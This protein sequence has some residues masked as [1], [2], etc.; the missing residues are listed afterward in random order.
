MRKI[1]LTFAILVFSLVLF[2][3]FTENFDGW[4]DG[5]YAGVV[6]YEHTGVGHWENNNAMVHS[7]YARSGNAV[8]FNDDSSST[9]EYLLFKGLDGNGKDGGI[10][11]ISFWYRHWDGNVPS[12]PI[13]F[14]VEYQVG[15]TT[16]D[17]TAIGSSVNVTSTTYTEYSETANISGDDIFFRVRNIQDKERLL[18]DD[19][20]VT[21]YSGGAVTTPVIS[22]ISNTPTTPSPSEDVVVSATITDD[23]TINSAVINWGLTTGSLTNNVTMSIDSGDVYVGTI[24][25]QADGATVYY[26]ITAT[27]NDSNAETS[28]ERS[29]DVVLPIVATP[30]FTPGAGIYSETQSVEILCSTV[31][32]SIYYTTDG[33][34]PTDAST[35]Y[36]V[37]LSIDATTTVKAKA[38][39]TG[40]GPSAVA[41]AL[42]DFA[43]A[44]P[45]NIYISEYIE[46]S[47]NNKAIEIYNAGD[48]DVNL[49]FVEFWRI[50]NGG[51]WAV[52]GSGNAVTLSGT[53]APGDVYVVCNSSASAEIQALSDLVG[54]SVCYFN[55]DDAMGLVYNGTLVDVVGDE[56]ADPGS[57]W[58]VAGETDAT[59]NHTLLRKTTGAATTDW[60]ASSGTNATDSQW[61]VMANDDIS[62]LGQ[63]TP[64]PAANPAPVI[65]NIAHT[66]ETPE[67]TDIVTVTADI[68]DD[69]GLTSA[70][71]NWGL[72]SDAMTNNVAMTLSRDAYEGNIPAQVG[73]TTV[74]YEIVAID[75]NAEPATTTSATYDYTVV[76]IVNVADIATLRAG[77]TDG[78]IYCLTGEAVLTYQQSYRGQKFVQDATA[79]ILIDDNSGNITTTYNIYDGITGLCGTL[80]E[81][82]GM[83]QF[84]PVADPGAASNT[85]LSI[86]PVVVTLAD[87]TANFETYE[88]Q[89]VTV[90]DLTFGET[91]NFAN[92]TV[93]TLSDGTDSY[94]FRTSFYDVDYIGTA[95]PSGTVSISGIMNSR[96]DG[97]YIS[98]RDAADIVTA[99]VP[100]VA[101]PTFNPAAG[102][103]ATAQSVEILCATAGASIYYTTDGT[104]PDET[105]T[106]YTVAIDVTETTTIRAKAYLVD[107]TASD[108]AEAVYTIEAIVAPNIYISEYIEGS[109]S[110][111]AF[112]IYNADTVP[113]DLSMVQV[114][115]ISNGG[116][117]SEGA[118]NGTTLVGTLNPGEVW[119][120]ANSSA[121]PEIQA[122][123]DSVGSSI[124]WFN[125]D[126]AMGLAYNGVLIDVVGQEGIDPGTGWDVAGVTAATANHTLLRKSSVTTGTTDWTTSAGTDA[127]DSQWIVLGEDDY[128]NLGDTTANYNEAPAITNILVNPVAPEVGMNVTI[129]ADVTDD[130]AVSTVELK[131][132]TETGV[133]GTVVTMNTRATYTTTLTT[134]T[135]GTYYFVVEA[136]DDGSVVTTSDEQTF[137]VTEP[138]PTEGIIVSETALAFAAEVGATSDPQEYT[139]Q[140]IDLGDVINIEVAGPFEVS[141]NALSWDTDIYDLDPDFDGTIWVRYT[142]TAAGDEFGTITHMSD[143]FDDVVINLT[144]TGSLPLVDIFNEDFESTTLG[145][146]TPV[147]VI[148]DQA[149]EARSYSGNYYAYMSGFS[150]SAQDNEDWLISPAVNMDAYENEQLNFDTAYNYTGPALEVYV[151]TDYVD[152]PTTATWAPLNPVL[153]TGGFS[154]ANSG[155][156]D[157]SGYNGSLRV[158]FKYQS[159]PTNGSAAWEIDNIVMQGTVIQGVNTAPVVTNVMTSPAVPTSTDIVTVTADIADADGISS[160][161]LYWGLASDA[162][163]NEVPMTLNRD[164]YTADIPAQTGGTVVYLKVMATD[165]HVEPMTGESG[166][167]NY[168][169]IQD[170]ADIAALRAGATDGTYYQLAGEVILTFQQ[171][172]RGQKYVQ[173]ASGAI[174]IDD[175]AGAITTAYN[176]YDGITGLWG[177]LS[178]YGEMLQFVPAGDPGAATTTGNTITPAVVTLTDLTNNFEMYEAQVVTVNDVNFEDVGNFANGTV[179]SVSDGAVNYSF[180]STFYDVDYIG[181][182]IPSQP[183]NITG[184]MNSRSTGEYLTARFLTDLDVNETVVAT[185][186]FTPA[187]G[188]YTETQNVEILCDTADAMIY[189]TTDGTDPDESSSL[190]SV[191]I[192]VSETTTIK[193]KAYK[194]GFTP[195]SISE[196][197]YTIVE[198]TEVNIYISEYL[199]GSSNN[200]AIEIYNAGADPVNLDLVEFWRIS[201]G[202]D[203]AVEGSGNAV[204]LSGTLAP[205]DVYVVCNS[206]A[207]PE[208]QAVS[209][210]VGTSICYFNGDDAMGLAYNGVL[211]DVVGD[212]G[213]DPGS[214]WDVAGETAATA[215]HTLLRKETV[216]EATTDWA[217]SA[218]DATDSQWTVME[219]DDYSNLGFPT[220]QGGA[221]D[222][223]T[224]TNVVLVNDVTGRVLTWDAAADAVTYKVYSST[225][226]ASAFD[227]WTLETTTDQ[228]T[229]T[230]TDNA[231]KKFYRIV[232]STDAMPVRS[233]R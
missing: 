183:V 37:A 231:N 8:R 111:K 140:G 40:Y 223:A 25:A 147:S 173:D 42:Y 83:L 61:T 34:E 66:P 179:Y 161:T 225:D 47:S 12:E 169:V 29:Y 194:D 98:A 101:T 177:T 24:P 44:G 78:T 89:V 88:A 181:T 152:D 86:T 165:A 18:I 210:L 228:L 19:M 51:D 215:N 166:V 2:A 126:D 142:A 118:S 157:L 49:G 212:E 59:A 48:T 31:G 207:I 144:G 226:P 172:Y 20:T 26:T 84:I 79:G 17:W 232:S 163:T 94:N 155:I 125:G 52:E 69:D 229:W 190:Y 160:A 104:D 74:Y 167:N 156:L 72:A 199:E 70:T 222:P 132:G 233:R 33:S 138:A 198:A 159:D 60:A 77:S 143:G 102:T 162:L 134:L 28:S 85:G 182:A 11:T 129:T 133:Y 119:V 38:Y 203:W 103:Y 191:A 96:N 46:G 93:Y 63:P 185:P 14:I 105:S 149:W 114:W 16:G 73:G 87:L 50:S 209:D 21:D 80:N 68:T 171:S 99:T 108:I 65:A 117:W 146:W 195:S 187:A 202:G 1:I 75:A 82:G 127:S 128:S 174:L 213:A 110:N 178:S 45:A 81:Y 176:L 13:E 57:G 4:S 227:S 220:G 35:L 10:G 97:E 107:Y 218:G 39:M 120:N 3:D 141:D 106:M 67:A 113:V 5:S 219:I 153:S 122:L 221:A 180:R 154:W 192:A 7:T 137:T 53:L 90:N 62:N 150:G 151:S 188:T 123:A 196:A 217:L 131:Y 32:A 100:V 124:T 92:G 214:G 76:N 43:V 41:E 204:A 208:I 56:G 64:P 109:S 145:S 22:G 230:D 168:S 91:G 170:V 135:A 186:T 200:K 206:S 205:G 27:D 201:N 130:S 55:G 189:Y 15:G 30:Y 184:I 139:L 148:G 224:P 95:I 54:T 58:D 9:M 121:I 175:N 164:S 36:T 158:G 216:T 136:T 193:A 116:D 197:V 6:T 112:E 71:L 115:R 211:I 23:G